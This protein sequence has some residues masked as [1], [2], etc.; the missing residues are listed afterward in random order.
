MSFEP[1]ELTHESS[2][3]ERH[4]HHGITY[5]VNSLEI[6]V[7]DTN[8]KANDDEPANGRSVPITPYRLL[9]SLMIVAFGVSKAATSYRGMATMSTILDFVAGVTGT[10][11]FPIKVTKHRIYGT[12][13]FVSLSI[14]RLLVGL[15][16][17][18]ATGALLDWAFVVLGMIM[19]WVRLD[20]FARPAVWVQYFH[21]DLVT[22]TRS[23]LAIFVSRPFSS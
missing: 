11:L 9:V 10:F 18:V 19:Y 3:T 15:R 23:E 7:K 14:A 1:A 21:L 16:G 8:S 5:T 22:R 2:L 17:S 6:P 4:P 12:L 20:E 13:L